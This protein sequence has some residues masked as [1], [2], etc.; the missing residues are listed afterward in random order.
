MKTK[1]IV[2]L[3]M[4]FFSFFTHTITYAGLE[5]CTIRLRSTDQEMDHDSQYWVRLFETASRVMIGYYEQIGDHGKDLEDR[6]TVDKNL[7]M[8]PGAERINSLDQCD[9][10]I[11]MQAVGNNKWHFETEGW[12]RYNDGHVQHCSVGERE[13]NSRGSKSVTCQWHPSPS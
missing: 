9:I 10:E 3:S 13:L 4:C 12:F 5:N 6:K 8:L 11:T 1:A 2:I 7:R